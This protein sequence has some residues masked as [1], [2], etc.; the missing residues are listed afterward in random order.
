MDLR[1][2][3]C[4]YVLRYFY[5]IKFQIANKSPA[6]RLEK[7]PIKFEGGLRDDATGLHAFIFMARRGECLPGA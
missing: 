2:V 1:S 3:V 7:A 4:F 5:G 6:D